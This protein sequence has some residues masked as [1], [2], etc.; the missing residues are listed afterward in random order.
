MT[1]IC[2]TIHFGFEGS[3]IFCTSSHITHFLIYNQ[4]F[5]P[6]DTRQTIVII[7]VFVHY[8][9]CFNRTLSTLQLMGPSKPWYSYWGLG[10]VSVPSVY[11]SRT[12]AIPYA[13]NKE[14]LS[15]IWRT[16]TNA[17]PPRCCSWWPKRIGWSGAL[18][19]HSTPLSHQPLKRG[20]DLSTPP[21]FKRTASSIGFQINHGLDM[22]CSTFLLHAVKGLCT[23]TLIVLFR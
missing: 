15:S 6:I 14:G 23:R 10:I 11:K 7:L 19:D 4:P 1:L 20:S 2:E 18:R 5:S 3:S 22:K 13:V 9:R 17:R 21:S 12:D 8:R 16:M